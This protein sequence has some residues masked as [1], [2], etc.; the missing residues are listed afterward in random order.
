MRSYANKQKGL[1]LITVLFIFALVSLLAISM[2]TRQKMSMAQASATINLTQAQLLALSIEDVAKAGMVL[3]GNRDQDKDQPWDTSAEQWNQFPPIEEAGATIE[4]YIRDLQGLFN[5]NSLSKVGAVNPEN[6]I[7][8]RKRFEAL[9]GEVGVISG[10]TTIADNVRDWLDKDSSASSIYQNMEP[11]Y[12]ASG[13]EFSHPSELLLIE[14][15]D[16]EIYSKI[17][18]YIT[19]LPVNTTLNINT[20]DA[21]ILSSWDSKLSQEDAETIVNKTHPGSCGPT[22]RNDNV[23]KDIEGEVFAEAALAELVKASGEQGA[24][25]RWD[26]ADFSLDSKYFSFLIRVQIDGQDM[27]LE[28]IIKRDMDPKDGF[29]GVVYRDFSRK[30]ADIDRLKI[31][32]C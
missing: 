18:P 2:Q 15:V 32:K 19:A 16:H 30:P 3:D 24:T 27:M 1:A 9:L 31:N 22:V 26:E 8:A 6:P 11:P 21:K 23:Y 13:I 17:E 12:S 10:S 20:T 4:I 7:A 28:S 14:G 25:G 5:L 29:V